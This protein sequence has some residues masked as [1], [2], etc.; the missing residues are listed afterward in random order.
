VRWSLLLL[1]VATSGCVY[2][3]NVLQTLDEAEKTL[4]QANAVHART[5]APAELA[6][7]EAD[8]AFTHLE[9]EDGDLPRAQDHA[10]AAKSWAAKAVEVAT[11][12]GTADRDGDGIIDLEDQC[13]DEP[14]DMD[15]VD[16][17]DGCRDVDPTADDDG[18]GIIN[19]DDA[20][21]DQPED[22]DGDHDE[23]GCPETSEDTD[24]DG[25]IDAI[26]QCPD[27]AEDIDHFND[28]DGCPDPDNDNDGVLDIHDACPTIPEDVD[29]WDD[30]DGCPDADNDS[31]GIADVDDHCPNQAGPPENHGCPVTDADADGIA[32]AN[33]ACPNE[34]ETVNGYL[35]DDGCPDTPP[36]RV[37]V[38]HEQI[39]LD[40]HVNFEVG[41]ATL[42]PDS[43]P[44][45]D[46][47]AKVLT[48]APN[49]KLRIEGHT[50]SDGSEDLNLK[51]SQERAESV[52]AYLIRKGIDGS[53]MKAIGF[54]ETRPIDTNRT[55]AGRANNRRVQ[56]DIVSQ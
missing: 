6:Q 10:R 5:C 25:V 32:D 31:D 3:P 21:I 24:G 28:D 48:D 9:L 23:D 36:T 35:D 26:D 40:D 46:D 7:A 17:T 43:L 39:T 20:C 42:L 51:L 14:E 11:P 15:G 1:A 18:D 50:D 27:Q 16:D 45:L 34:P 30:Q 2:T 37:K 53:R 41:K 22:M 52:R 19:I 29:G 49:M 47:V 13:P 38:T 8:A 54:G 33:D 56:F 44:L 4:D 12:C 55:P